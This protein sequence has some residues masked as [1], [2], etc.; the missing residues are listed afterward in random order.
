LIG[1]VL[2]QLIMISVL[3]LFAV[4]WGPLASPP[5]STVKVE[6]LTIADALMLAILPLMSRTTARLLL[7]A[8]LLGS[9]LLAAIV[10]SFGVAWNMLEYTGGSHADAIR[11]SG[12]IRSTVF[13]LYF[14]VSVL[15]GAVITS[16]G[17]ISLF[18]LNLWVNMVNG[19]LLPF[20]IGCVFYIACWRR[21]LPDE[22]RM[23]RTYAVFAGTL[24]FI[25]SSLSIYSAARGLLLS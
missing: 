14:I 17:S 11:G 25:C 9:S 1:S 19:M 4:Q 20:V 10:S 8:A 5:R 18:R 13:R 6:D 16:S 15:C 23:S 12:A 21:V 2:T 24:L 3:V 22:H 7:G